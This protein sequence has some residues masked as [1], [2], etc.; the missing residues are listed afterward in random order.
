MS[1]IITYILP[2]DS[3]P[4]VCGAVSLS[5]LNDIVGKPIV[6]FFYG[7]GISDGFC[8]LR[9]NEVALSGPFYLAGLEGAVNMFLDIMDGL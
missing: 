5:L 3:S 6:A 9:I 4:L 2:I 7:N 1:Y 8:L